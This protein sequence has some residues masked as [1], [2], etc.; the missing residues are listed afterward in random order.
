MKKLTKL[1]Q[2][3]TKSLK[4]KLIDDY[5]VYIIK[6]YDLGAHFLYCVKYY[7]KVTLLVTPSK[8]KT[9]IECLESVLSNVNKGYKGGT[10]IRIRTEF[11]ILSISL[12]HSI[13]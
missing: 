6:N 12:K 4:S 11:N 3:I 2:G 7:Q 8:T 5:L 13:D 10:P 1:H 9:I